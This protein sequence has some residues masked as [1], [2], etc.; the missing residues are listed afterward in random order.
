[1]ALALAPQWRCFG[2]LRRARLRADRDGPSRCSTGRAGTPSGRS[3]PFGRVARADRGRVGGGLAGL[4]GGAVLQRHH[5]GRERR[6]LPAHLAQLRGG[7]DSARGR[8]CACRP[9]RRRRPG[10]G[11][12]AARRGRR[13]RRARSDTGPPPWT[14]KAGRDRRRRRVEGERS[15]SLPERLLGHRAPASARGRRCRVDVEVEGTNRTPGRCGVTRTGTARLPPTHVVGAPRR[16]RSG[17][18]A[19]WA[20][21]V[22]APCRQEGSRRAAGPRPADV[23]RRPRA[24]VERPARPPRLAGVGVQRVRELAW[25]G[26]GGVEPVDREPQGGA[27]DGEDHGDAGHEQRATSHGAPA[28]PP[29]TAGRAR[30]AGRGRAAPRRNRR[31]ARCP[32]RARGR[33]GRPRAR[34]RRR[35]P[36]RRPAPHAGAASAA[37][38]DDA[39]RCRRRPRPAPAAPRGRSRRA[40]RRRGP[41]PRTAS[42]TR[43]PDQ[44]PRRRT[45]GAAARTR[46]AGRSRRARRRQPEPA[47]P[48]GIEHARRNRAGSATSSDHSTWAASGASTSGSRAERRS[49]PPSAAAEL[50]PAGEATS[51]RTATASSAEAGERPDQPA[52]VAEQD[53]EHRE[54]GRSRRRRPRP[55]AAR[56]ASPN[57]RASARALSPWCC[58]L[59][60]SM[61][62]G[63]SCGR[64]V[65]RRAVDVGGVQPG[66]AP[67]R[68][69]RRE[70]GVVGQDPVDLDGEAGATGYGA[71]AAYTPTRAALPREVSNMIA[72]PVVPR[73]SKF[74][75]TPPSAASGCRLTKASAPHRQASSASVNR[76]TSRCAA[77]APVSARDGLQQGRH[78]RRRRR[79]RRGRLDRV[80]V[81]QRKSRPVGAVPGRTA[82]TL[83]TRAIAVSPAR[84]TPRRQRPAPGCRGRARRGC[85]TNSSTTGRSRRCRRRASARRSAPRAR[86]PARR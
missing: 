40:R 51:A 71:A 17:R 64:V 21:P 65:D 78:A 83:R 70:V 35:R 10:A 6:L 55:A 11:S 56:S 66:E 49:R 45:G 82:T 2:H 72:G 37:A 22:P 19:G 41:A 18:S 60:G 36:P 75:A 38:R 73:A 44:R 67:S 3:R 54:V 47:G 1:M 33:T 20:Q 34:A 76:K 86:T 14:A 77:A 13:W 27:G 85:A 39:R 61:R 80:V 63:R 79:C 15:E 58:R 7:A 23:R 30:A 59:A 31:P 32:G 43:A 74:S 8:S 81:G 29:G 52:R 5:R 53:A 28:G 57:A 62:G 48:P 69:E 4:A 26:V 84:R 9:R 16:R 24:R 25:A 46:R 50:S 42:Q 12:P 68:Q